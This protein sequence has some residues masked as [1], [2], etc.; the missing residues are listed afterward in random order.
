MLIPLAMAAMLP[1][2]DIRPVYDGFRRGLIRW[3]RNLAA[4]QVLTTQ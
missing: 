4:V 1:T 2:I 3:V